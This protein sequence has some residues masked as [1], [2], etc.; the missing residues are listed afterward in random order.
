MKSIL[1]ALSIMLVFVF[2]TS[3]KKDLKDIIAETK[4]AT[5][6]VYTYDEY[7]SPSGS[8]SGFFID[9]KGTAITNFHVLDGS[10]KAV[11]KTEDGIEYEIDQVV[12]SDEKWDIAKFTIKNKVNKDFPYLKFADK[13]VEQGDKVY[14]I[15]APL[16]LEHT[17]SEGIVSS[18]RSDSHGKVIQITAPISPGSSGSAILNEQGKVMAVATFQKKGGQ[19]LNFGV[20]IDTDRLALLDKNDFIKKHPNFNKKDNFII[21]NI[22]DEGDGEVTLHALEFK[23]DATVAYLSYTNLDMAYESLVIW[24]ELNKGDES[25]TIVDKDRN[26]KYHVVSST[27]GVDKAN[28]TDVALASNY[29]FKVYFPAIKDELNNISIATG[30]TTRD[31]KFPN[32]NL[33]QYRDKIAYDSEKYIK[34]YAYSTMHKGGLEEAVSIFGTIL[35]ENPEDV[36]ALN[37]MGII[38]YVIDNNMDALHYFTKAIE[39]HPNNTLGLHNR[40]YLY[41]YQKEYQKALDD[42]VKV[43]SIDPVQPDN[44]YFR[45][46][47]YVELEKFEEAI[48]DFSKALESADFKEEP[49][50]YF[51]RALCYIQVGKR[52]EAIDDVQ[53]AYNYNSDSEMEQ[54]LQELWAKLHQ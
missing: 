30:T 22:P 11:I 52:K 33:N 4:Q 21:L 40:S 35:D 53:M 32:I 14:N 48:K 18:L 36:Q 43:I 47:I 27:I 12:A 39:T 51:Y 15:S 5:F 31:W 41:K 20:S 25:F 37:A 19:N 23:A 16:G 13:V 49:L 3:C 2:L 29:R 8:G 38:S 10:T 17:V 34:E 26:K 42:I 24:C 44:Y 1:N 45:A 9:A 50:M 6:T 54:T 28:G 46:M 7:G